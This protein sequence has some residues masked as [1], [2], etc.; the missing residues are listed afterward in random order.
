MDPAAASTDIENKFRRTHPGWFYWVRRPLFSVLAL[1][2][3]VAYAFFL[4][5][6]KNTAP[7]V[8]F[9]FSISL[10]TLLVLG[11][12]ANI[13]AD[14][15]KPEL[16][17]MAV[18]MLLIAVLCWLFY[19]YSGAQWGRLRKFFFN[20]DK[21]AGN[22]WILRNG[23]GVTLF[24]A[25]ISAV[26][27]VLTGLLVAILRA[28]NSPTLNLF[29]KA[30]VDIFRSVPMIVIMVILFFALPFA[31][32]S[33]GSILSTVVALSLGYGA[34][35]AESFRA[36]IES[37]HSGQIEAARSLGLSRWQTMRKVILPQAIPVV[38]PPLTG[39]LVA[40]LKD[41]AVAS[42]VAAPELLKR[43]RELYTSK[44]NPTPLVAAALIY[45]AVLIPLV[46]VV[47]MLE[48]RLKK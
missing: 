42:V 31:G 26:G 3:L 46:R 18:S 9:Y 32:I 1:V 19:R 47:N 23:L 34:Y 6:D 41:T 10:F 15:D 30:Y 24:L 25:L 48:N 4:L 2:G 33:L 22:W 14:R 43:A 44:T 28:Y 11:Y 39:N 29:L 8:W 16:L 45:L 37:V 12:S 17:Q 5:P 40:M 36:G 20:W 38:I 7:P 21:L 27:S 35:T 13:L